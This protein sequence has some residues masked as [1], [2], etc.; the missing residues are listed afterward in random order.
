MHLA[1]ASKHFSPKN[2]TNMVPGGSVLAIR[3]CRMVL[4][5]AVQQKNMFISV[6]FI[7]TC[8]LIRFVTTSLVCENNGDKLHRRKSMRAAGKKL[9]INELGPNIFPCIE[10]CM[11]VTSQ[12]VSLYYLWLYKQVEGSVNSCS[13]SVIKIGKYPVHQQNGQSLTMQDR[14]QYM[15]NCHQG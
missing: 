13:P 12:I 11:L 8:T 3:H 4:L 14:Q 10:V 6:T 9:I 1:I 5:D 7:A 2:P 15:K